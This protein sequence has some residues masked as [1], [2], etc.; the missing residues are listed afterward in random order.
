MV[1]H[2]A[3]ANFGDFTPAEAGTR[4]SD[5]EGIQAELTWVV[6]ISQGSLPAKFCQLSQK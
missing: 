5:P 4:F 6:V 1:S 2:P 3:E